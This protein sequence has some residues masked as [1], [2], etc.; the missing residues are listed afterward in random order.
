MSN[1]VFTKEEVDKGIAG[2]YDGDPVVKVG[3]DD[4][5]NSLIARRLESTQGTLQYNY[6]ESCI[7]MQ[8]GGAI[9][10]DRDRL[11]FNIQKPHGM[12]NAAGSCTFNLHIHWEQPDDTDRE[13]TVQY[14]VQEN[15]ALKNT[16]WTTAV[17]SSNDNNVFDYTSGTLN[18]ITKLVD[19]DLSA[20]SLSST[21]QFRL[22]RTDS[23]TG[24]INAVF[25]DV[26]VP[27][28]QGRGSREE[29]IQ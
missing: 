29:F 7:T 18:Q 3:W 17:V 13:F 4:L 24:D 6:D 19:I 21:V 15:N 22:A 14:R 20:V 5:A 9:D 1:P 26:H 11:I 12:C 28:I 23:E 25:V 27:Y 10:D 8:P 16:T 2:A